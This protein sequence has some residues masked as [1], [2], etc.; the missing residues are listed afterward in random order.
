MGLKKPNRLSIRALLFVLLGAC[1]VWALVSL[2]SHFIIPTV[3]LRETQRSE[4]EL[5]GATIAPEATPVMQVSMASGAGEGVPVTAATWIPETQK[6]EMPDLLPEYVYLYAVNSD[7]GGWLRVRAIPRIDFAWV[8][9][10]NAYYIH[11][12]FY[13]R[14]SVGGTAF[15]DECCTDWPQDPNLIIYAHNL[16]SGDMFGE[17][18]RLME[19]DVLTASPLIDFDTLYEKGVYVPVAVCV[20]DINPGTASYFDFNVASFS[21]PEAFG[22]YIARA[23]ELSRVRYGADAEYG[24]RLLTLVT[25]YD[26]ANQQRL[27]VIARALREGET[28]ESVINAFFR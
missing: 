23:K 25:C 9:G 12:D 13:G 6:A 4:K 21:G 8:R 14:E 19:A 26:D 18:H 28:E 22:A 5:V 17:L 16:K 15:L 11:K 3:E 27:L 24:D 1:F 2:V 7:M 10:K 20:C